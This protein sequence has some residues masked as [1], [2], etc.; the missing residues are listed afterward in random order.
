MIRKSIH[1]FCGARSEPDLVVHRTGASQAINTHPL[2]AQIL[3]NGYEC[4][5]VGERPFLSAAAYQPSGDFY[6]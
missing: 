4:V 3:K 5:A 6:L 2:E 1:G